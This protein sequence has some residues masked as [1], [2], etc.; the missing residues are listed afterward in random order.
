MKLPLTSRYRRTPKT[1]FGGVE[2]LSRWVGFTEW[3]QQPPKMTITV[4]V[5]Y[6]GRADLLALKYLGS[7]EWW[8]VLKYYNGAFS[9]NWPRPGDEIK[10]PPDNIDL[11]IR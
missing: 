11:Y 4:P 6:A 2:T 9:I 7:V 3:L 8:W 1:V 10:I 5:E